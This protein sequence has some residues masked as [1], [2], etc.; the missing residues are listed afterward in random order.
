MMATLKR[1]LDNLVAHLRGLDPAIAAFVGGLCFFAL[2]YGMAAQRWQFFPYSVVE[3]AASAWRALKQIDTSPLPNGAELSADATP[4]P[5][6]ETMGAAG[7]ELLLVTGGPYQYLDKCPKYG[8]FAWIA[9]RSGNVLHTWNVDLDDLVSRMT[10][11]SGLVEPRNVYPVGIAL[12]KDGNL[13]AALHASNA[14]PYQAGLVKVDRD[15]KIVWYRKGNAHHWLTLTPDGK[16]IT[17]SLKVTDGSGY[18]GHTAILERCEDKVYSEGVTIYDG[19]GNVLKEISITDAL[20]KGG[21]PGLLYSVRDDCDP[22]HINSVEQVSE[23]VA[24]HLPGV[25]AGDILASLRSPSAIV[26]L[27]AQTGVAKRAVSGLTAGQHSAH[28]LPDGS[29]LVF[30]NQGGD[31]SHGGSRVVRIDL[32]TATAETVFPNGTADAPKLFSE[33]RGTVSISPDHTRALVSAGQAGTTTEI[34]IAS[35]DPLWR[36]TQSFSVLPYLKAHDIESDMSNAKFVAYGAY[37][38]PGKPSWL[39]EAH[40]AVPDTQ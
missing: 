7:S 9:D 32:N 20:E 13:F 11:F 25:D 3:E 26:I 18:V 4:A 27:D 28:F 21:Y 38:L 37:Y 34:A 24:A 33:E 16:I 15:G 36:M 14:F 8:C 12:D 35:G 1:A 23:E 22:V 5:A 2:V 39:R 17:P 10:G 30:D 40:A 19:E 29:V 31:R 6:I